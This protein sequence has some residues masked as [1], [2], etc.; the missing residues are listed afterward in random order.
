MND[1]PSDLLDKF[2]LRLPEGMRDEIREAAVKRGRSMN[3][4]IVLRLQATARSEQRGNKPPPFN[5]H[6][7]RELMDQ[8]AL[9]ALESGRSINAEIVF[10]LKQVL[11]D[12]VTLKQINEKL[13][14]LL[15]RK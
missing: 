13:D 1:Y 15:E 3:S 9:T 11:S 14:R 8:V 4:E 5:L 6:I 2:T 12:Q 10:L 7:S